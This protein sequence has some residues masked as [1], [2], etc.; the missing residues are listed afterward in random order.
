MFKVKTIFLTVMMVSTLGAS[1][2]F[3]DTVDNKSA[4]T[5]TNANTTQMQATDNNDDE[6]HGNWGLLGLLGLAG[7]AG[8]KRR[9]RDVHVTRTTTD[10]H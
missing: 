5:T 8:L 1:A 4:N 7:L 10:R 9:D 2:A 6:D 3:A